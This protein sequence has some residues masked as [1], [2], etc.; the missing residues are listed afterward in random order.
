M[1]ALIGSLIEVQ[2]PHSDESLMRGGVS[3]ASYMADLQNTVK[4]AWH[5][6][7]DFKTHRAVASFTIHEGGELSDVK[8]EQSSGIAAFDE[9]ALA[10]VEDAAPFNR[11]PAGSDESIP[12]RFTFDY[13]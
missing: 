10:A 5:P 2:K 3:Y 6:P 9:S 13:R 8:L 11:L 12:I 4:A 7:H 1:A